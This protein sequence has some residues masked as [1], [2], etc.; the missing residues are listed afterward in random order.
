M[1]Y[2]NNRT[3]MDWQRS[4]YIDKMLTFESKHNPWTVIIAHCSLHKD[5]KDPWFVM[6]KIRKKEGVKKSKV[7]P[8]TGSKNLLVQL[9]KLKDEDYILVPNK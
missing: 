8:I 7:F 4:I 9:K 6:T 1:V 5:P 3:I 2:I